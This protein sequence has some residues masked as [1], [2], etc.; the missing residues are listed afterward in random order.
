MERLTTAGEVARSGSGEEALAA[1]AQVYNGAAL[2][3]SDVGLPD[4]A[5]DWCWEHAHAYLTHLPLNTAMAQRALEPVVNLARLRIRA[6]NGTAAFAML[7]ALR[8]GLRAAKATVVDG[9]ELPL[10]RII[11]SDEDRAELHRWLWTV[12][13]GDGMRALA[14][15]GRWQE[16]AEQA[17]QHGGIGD[18]LFDG[19]QVAVIAALTEGNSRTALAMAEDSEVRGPWERAVQA[20]LALWCHEGLGDAT[21]DDTETVLN[22]VRAVESRQVVFTTR[23]RIVTAELIESL[24]GDASVLVSQLVSTVVRAQDGYAARDLL[25][26]WSGKLSSDQMGSLIPVL[27]SS[28]LGRQTLPEQLFHELCAAISEASQRLGDHSVLT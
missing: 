5:R 24:R 22:R 20:V 10:D 14:T 21:A 18:R 25:T 1:A 9:H 16:A 23:L 2:L 13:L 17:R 26:T 28:G 15:E 19:R 27:Q 12:C 4:L 6:G 11:S 7:T 3:A 8:E